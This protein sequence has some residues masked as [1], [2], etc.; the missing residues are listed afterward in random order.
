MAIT[1]ASVKGR[2]LIVSAKGRFQISKTVNAYSSANN[3]KGGMFQ[4]IPA[5]KMVVFGIHSIH[6]F[7]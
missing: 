7:A 2:K 5:G 3:T 6:P 1:P 4:K